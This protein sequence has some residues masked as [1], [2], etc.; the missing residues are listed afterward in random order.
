MRFPPFDVEEPRLDKGD[1]ILTI[2]PDFPI[3]I[4]LDEIED[5][6]VFFIIST[7]KIHKIL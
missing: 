4:Q 2:E 5:D 6:S 1:N 7:P 3:Q